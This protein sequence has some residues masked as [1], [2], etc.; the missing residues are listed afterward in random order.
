MLEMPDSGAQQTPHSCNESC[1][2]SGCFIGC[3][4]LVVQIFSE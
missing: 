3:A 4:R 2:Y 1:G